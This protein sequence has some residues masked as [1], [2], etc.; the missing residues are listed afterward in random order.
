MPLVA[1]VV[2]L[3]R[4]DLSMDE[5]VV[6]GPDDHPFRVPPDHEQKWKECVYAARSCE[7]VLARL[8][9]PLPGSDLAVADQ[10]YPW[11]KVS[12]W[13]RDY[14]RAS[15]DHLCLWADV[16]APDKFD[17]DTVNNI[18]MR[19]YLSLARAGLEAA[20]HALWLTE[21]ADAREC[22]KRFLRLMYRDFTYHKKALEAD[23]MDTSTID[24]RINNLKS[25]VD[26]HSIP[27]T[28]TEPVP[29]YEKMVRLAATATDHA[30]DRWAY[31]WHAASGAAHGQ[32]WFSLEAYALVPVV[33]YE[34]GHFRTITIP[35][36]EFITDT[37]RAACDALHWGTLRWLLMGRHDPNMLRQTLP[38]VHQRMPNLD[39]TPRNRAEN[40]Q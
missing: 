37:I 27:V 3:L 15:A 9:D 26:E 10:F 30:A 36:P 20:G 39:G 40:I 18:R 32:N 7:L 33:E 25:R 2:T 4:N 8:P 1:S 29:G 17:A 31:L 34:P 24:E 19:P 16:I 22:V 35:D 38:E 13:V 28:L 21:V 14:L 11:E 23:N 12:T 5:A 6:A